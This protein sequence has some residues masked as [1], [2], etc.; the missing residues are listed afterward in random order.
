MAKDDT[1]ALRLSDVSEALALL[2]RLPVQMGAARGNRAAWAWPLVGVVTGA[3]AGMVAGVSLWLGLPLQIAAGLAI[4]SQI[5]ATGALH[6]D[7]L[8]D[9]ADGFWGASTTPNRLKIMKDS[10]IGTYG[11]LALVLSVGLR[12]QALAFVMSYGHIFGPV[13]VAGVVSRT[14]MLVLMARLPFARADGLA[15]HV[16]QPSG[17]TMGLGLVVAAIATLIFGGF[18]ALPL[19]VLVV[20]LSWAWERLAMAKIGGQTGDVLGS[21]QQVTE[22]I[23]LAAIAAML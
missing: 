1:S 13:I 3:I 4:A 11:V 18:W 16:G 19:A 5:L 6:E 23:A 10:H 9:C 12:W 20:L 21:A 2:T 14:P 17:Q 7:G 15:R 8:A 22:I